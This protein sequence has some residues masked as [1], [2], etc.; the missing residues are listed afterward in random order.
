ISE[1]L[2]LMK[3]RLSGFRILIITLLFISMPTIIM[4][5][6]IY[7]GQ[8]R[9]S[10][11]GDPIVSASVTLLSTGRGAVTDSVGQF[12][13]EA[14]VGEKITFSSI[15]Y[16]GTTIT[17]GEQTT[18]SVLLHSAV[19]TLDEVV[20]IGYGSARRSQVVGSVAKVDGE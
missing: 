13:I 5:Q 9:D 17:L 1:L 15:G 6:Q 19:G 16:S 12:S 10:V 8:V 11:T 18:L 14:S 20:I 7:T 2:S 3:A 4:A